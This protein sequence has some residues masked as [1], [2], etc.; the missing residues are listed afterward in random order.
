MQEKKQILPKQDSGSEVGTIN[1]KKGLSDDRWDV[2]LR[3]T[4]LRESVLSWYEFRPDADLLEIGR[5][6]TGR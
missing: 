3:D 1:K 2:N 4:V 6:L 5:D